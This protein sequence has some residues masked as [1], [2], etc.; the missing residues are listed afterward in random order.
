MSLPTAS[1]TA[2]GIDD[3]THRLMQNLVLDM[4]LGAMRQAG[5]RVSPETRSGMQR[6][7]EL[8]NRNPCE[9]GERAGGA[10]NRPLAM[11]MALLPV[12]QH[13]LRQGNGE[14]TRCEASEAASRLAPRDSLRAWGGFLANLADG[15]NLGNRYIAHALGH[16]IH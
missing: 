2:G 14:H 12:L 9:A 6:L 16:E 11:V 10:A 4:L 5:V 13:L 3:A 1:A 15:M 8:I 7:R